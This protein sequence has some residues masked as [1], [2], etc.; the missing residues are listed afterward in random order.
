MENAH[1]NEPLSEEEQALD[2]R[3]RRMVQNAIERNRIKGAPIACYD[4]ESKASYLLFANGE[5][6]YVS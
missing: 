5:R 3:M 6:Q 1:W 2:D 4:K